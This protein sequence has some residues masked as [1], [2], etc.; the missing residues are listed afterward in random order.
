MAFTGRQHVE[1]KKACWPRFLLHAQGGD[2]DLKD[3]RRGVRAVV[4]DSDAAW[5]ATAVDGSASAVRDEPSDA[6][7]QGIHSLNAGPHTNGRDKRAISG[8]TPFIKA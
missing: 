4:M 8:V 7:L 3:V 2:T 6:A 5:G 1:G